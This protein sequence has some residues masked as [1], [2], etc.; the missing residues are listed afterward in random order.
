[1]NNDQQAD[2]EY[3]DNQIHDS[4]NSS[5]RERI[6]I[7]YDSHPE[8]TERKLISERKVTTK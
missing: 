4:L 1:M 6:Q 2:L 3:K 5:N 8:S 7:I